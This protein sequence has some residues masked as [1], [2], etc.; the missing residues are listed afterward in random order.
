M[1]VMAQL[2][3]EWLC[4]LGIC[5]YHEWGGELMLCDWFNLIGA[6][7]GGHPFSTLCYG[8]IGRNLRDGLRDNHTSCPL[9]LL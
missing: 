6:S 4:V 7:Q 3:M 1:L 5:P 2:A 8:R 9:Y